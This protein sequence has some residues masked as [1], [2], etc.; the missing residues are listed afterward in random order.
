MHPFS[1]RILM[2]QAPPYMTS[3]AR[4][5]DF[6]RLTKPRLGILVLFA[7]AVG[8]LMASGS[9]IHWQALV[10]ALL[11]TA[12]VSGGAAVLNQAMEMRSDSLMTRTRNRPLPAGRIPQPTAFRVGLV[13]AFSGLAGLAFGTTA[14][15]TCI[16]AF[17]LLVYLVGY[18]PMKRQS[19][20]CMLVGAVAGALPPIIGWTAANGTLQW[21]SGVLFG[22]LFTWQMPHL[23]AITWMHRMDYAAA[24]F[25][26]PF[27]EG[28]ATGLYAVV[29][30]TMLL[31]ISML[32]LFWDSAGLS[33]FCGT[34]ILDG[35][36][37]IC[38]G[39]FLRNPNRESA[40]RLFV[41]SIF[42]LPVF[43]TLMLI[44]WK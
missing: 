5:W 20:A 34:L 35:M 19:S 16:A 33:Y 41:A 29:F 17:A 24:G 6:L 15:A 14:L 27:V 22:V 42:Y 18:T 13:M 7:T 4:G 12:L 38:S 25:P 40:R 1:D 10:F 23:A 37:L 8:F 36:I 31:G 26:F 9:E 21:E 39:L 3:I 43:F 28:R 30:S 32:P 11:G 2:E 44:T